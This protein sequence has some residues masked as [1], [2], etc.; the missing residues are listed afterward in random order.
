[1]TSSAIDSF[2]RWCPVTAPSSPS[3]L[4]TQFNTDTAYPLPTEIPDEA[5]EI[6]VYAEVYCG[7]TTP[8]GSGEYEIYVFQ[9][10]GGDKASFYLSVNTGPA[11]SYNNN[12]ANLWLPMPPDR[13]LHA[14]LTF[15]PSDQSAATALGKNIGSSLRVL[16]YRTAAW[17][18][19]AK[20]Q[21]ETL[22]CDVGQPAK[23]TATVT[24]SGPLAYQWYKNGVAV[25][26]ATTDTLALPDPATSDAG[27]YDVVV[28]SSL[29]SVTSNSASL[30]VTAPTV[31]LTA[32]T[33]A[34]DSGQPVNFT[35]T[36]TARQ[37]P[38]TFQ[39]RKDGTA[40]PG[41]TAAT[42]SLAS[43]Q[44][45]DSGRYDV[46]VTFGTHSVTSDPLTLAVTPVTVT[47]TSTDSL[48]FVGQ[49]VAF[50]ATVQSITPPT[51]Q[52]R[53][54]GTP[55]PDATT[56]SLLIAALR[57]EDE[58]TY[59]VVVTVGANSL[60]STP[61]A[62]T[63]VACTVTPAQVTADPGDTATLAVQVTT[64]A[65]VTY[66]WQKDGTDLPDATTATLSLAA[67]QPSD[68]GSYT[69][70][71]SFA[72]GTLTSPT[73]SVVVE[74]A[75][76]SAQVLALAPYAYWPLNDDA[77]ATAR[78]A[79]TGVYAGTP[80]GAATFE[81]GDLGSA[82]LPGFRAGQPVLSLNGTDAQVALAALGLTTDTLTVTGWIKPHGDQQAWAGLFFH[83][84]AGAT[85]AGLQYSG[86]ADAT[87]DLRAMWNGTHYSSA[88]GL[89]PPADQWSFVALTVTPSQATL[90]LGTPATGLQTV[91]LSGDFTPETF[92][93]AACLGRDPMV[94]GESRRF[95]G[96]LAHF[97]L[98]PAALSA[99]QLQ[100]LFQT[101]L[102]AG[103]T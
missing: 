91:Q 90:A 85:I 92:A 50:A 41:A 24:G 58:G 25:P 31:A 39:W 62:L 75:P 51:Y 61:L 29:H 86:T 102:S 26:G 13:T 87:S 34:C 5:R 56:A 88:S 15:R 3:A 100:T 59:D 14:A 2:A 81:T 53:L 33:T 8:Q 6:L 55:L 7:D 28:S 1:M 66:Q 72:N 16:A 42:L 65:T 83:R 71:L 68:S 80:Q 73:I 76:F 30:V 43:A 36:V 49:T 9:R 96:Q 93:D 60:T 18:L 4:P 35:A 32:S 20:I 70:V 54:N 10:R 46:L 69:V 45:T 48:C 47:T 78:D 22:N 77:G 44:P 63:V 67:L 89:V 103:Q 19:T 74:L 82:D 52:W 40:L 12:S 99:D 79:A 98:F 57:P 84:L 94:N 27:T 21:P 17:T 101:A 97:A 64:Q 38:T 23:F 11:S 95:T 37:K